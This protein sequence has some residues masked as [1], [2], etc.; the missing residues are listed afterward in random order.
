MTSEVKTEH[1]HI[2]RYADV[3]NGRPV[4]KG[5]SIPVGLIAQFYKHGESADEILNAY[6]HLT[7]A[8]VYDAISYYHDRQSEIE[9]ELDTTSLEHVLGANRLRLD[10]RGR[11]VPRRGNGKAVSGREPTC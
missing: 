9:A 5:T 10:E 8:A 7:L 2:V 6:P 4:I 1:P 11:I 3:R